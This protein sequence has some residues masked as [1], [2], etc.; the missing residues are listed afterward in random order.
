MVG[1][2]R[3]QDTRLLSH[4]QATAEKTQMALQPKHWRMS[5]NSDACGDYTKLSAKRIHARNGVTAYLFVDGVEVVVR[6][7]DDL[8]QIPHTYT[9]IS[10][11]G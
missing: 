11:T 4:S 3:M 9:S 7:C 5:S 10:T 2:W 8:R 1:K 6:Q